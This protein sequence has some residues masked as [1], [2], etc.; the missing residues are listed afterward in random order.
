MVERLP[1]VLTG[2]PMSLTADSASLTVAAHFVRLVAEYAAAQGLSLPLLL[3]GAGLPPD[4]LDDPD[5]RLPFR[6][7]D[8]LCLGAAD[9]L[10]DP[11]LGLRLGRTIKP[12]HFGPHGFGLISC[13]TVREL[14]Q[15]SMRYSGLVMDA[16]RNELVFGDTEVVRY[17][18]SN[19]PGGAP[20][21]RLQD[22]LN[23][24]AWVTLA[25]WITGRSDITPRWVS[26]R[27]A[28][29]VDVGV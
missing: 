18:R 21:G 26:F 19:L 17:W 13:T 11:G 23:M 5:A 3:A 15:H 16:C 1:A 20:V 22:D 6:A 9:A 25:R 2:K 4:G 8:R 7:F 12:G 29:P 24:A 14:L 10:A 28:A 27:H